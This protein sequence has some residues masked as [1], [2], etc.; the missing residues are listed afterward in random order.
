MGMVAVN[1][2]TMRALALAV[3]DGDGRMPSSALDIK[4]PQS[5]AVTDVWFPAWAHGP[6][7]R[8]LCA[9]S[10]GVTVHGHL[11]NLVDKD[12]G[13]DTL[14]ECASRDHVHL[15]GDAEGAHYA[16]MTR[17]FWR[18]LGAAPECWIGSMGIARVAPRMQSRGLAIA[19]GSTYLPRRGPTTAPT[20]VSFNVHAPADAAVLVTNIVGRYEL[21]EVVRAEAEG[22]SRAP[23]ASNELSQLFAAGH[24]PASWTFMVRTT[25]PGALDVVV[26]AG[27]GAAGSGAAGAAGAGTG[28]AGAGSG[29]TTGAGAAA[30]CDAT[31]VAPA[32]HA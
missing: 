17:G 2:A 12:L 8:L 15:G 7:G 16:G 26:V 5:Q 1:L 22:Q 14:F 24:A 32:K 20:L 25:Y 21:F 10:K 23:V 29:T 18:A 13:L 19:D 9:D 11:A 28:G 4:Q 30:A 27:A 3:R 31:Q 6:L